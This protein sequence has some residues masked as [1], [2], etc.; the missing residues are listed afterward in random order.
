MAVPELSIELI[1]E[2]LKKLQQ[3]IRAVDARGVHEEMTPC[4]A[5]VT[6]IAWKS[7]SIGSNGAS[8]L[9]MQ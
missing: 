3:Q 8:S 5:I 2:I 6:A 1:Y 7:V 9:Q 4:S